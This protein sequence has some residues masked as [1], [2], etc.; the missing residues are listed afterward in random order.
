[1]NE[2]LMNILG[3]TVTAIV[4]PLI[5]FLGLKLSEWLSTKIKDEKAAAL[6]KKATDIVLGAVRSVSQTY[7]ES[8]KKSGDFGKDAQL[9]ALSKAK[10]IALSQMGNDVKSFI[11]SNYGD[12]AK[13]LTNQI[14]AS[15]NQL[16]N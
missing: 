6:L 1:M 14:E 11:E 12:L 7:V 5:T 15:I 9:T 13:W 2:I 8:L 16:K 10:E 3:T 4:L